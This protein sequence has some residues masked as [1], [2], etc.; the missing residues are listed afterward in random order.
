LATGS[1]AK[2]YAA[3][4]V[5]RRD[6]V[7]LNRLIRKRSPRPQDGLV[8]VLDNSDQGGGDTNPGVANGAGA[9][10]PSDTGSSSAA[11]VASSTSAQS[12]PSTST[13][14]TPTP[15]KNTPASS[16]SPPALASVSF[17]L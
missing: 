11:S 5:H 1:D 3:V 12:T 17:Q 8:K 7:H 15:S 9:D 10:P 6:H 14:N 4:P 2:G 16:S 13:S